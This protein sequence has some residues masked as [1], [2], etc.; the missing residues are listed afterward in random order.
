[1]SLNISINHKEVESVLRKFYNA[2]GIAVE[3]YDLGLESVIEYP[4]ITN[5][6]DK[7]F[8][9]IIRDLSSTT[10]YKCLNCINRAIDKVCETKDSYIYSCHFGFMAIV[11]PI[12]IH[13]EVVAVVRSGPIRVV[14]TDKYDFDRIMS[15]MSDFD[16]LDLSNEEILLLRTSFNKIKFAK[17]EKTESISYLLNLCVREICVNN[18]IICDSRDLMKDF[19]YYIKENVREKLNISEV[20]ISLKISRSYLSYMLKKNK[21]MTFTEYVLKEKVEEAKKLLVTT[22]MPFKAISELLNF[23]SYVYFSRVFKGV[24]GYS[25]LEFR[26][27]FVIKKI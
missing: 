2:T 20:A 7:G 13:G 24:T 17:N 26:K 21:H 1:M 12:V 9:D 16:V 15:L 19:E 27:R 10:R 14:P 8:C 22:S 23:N 4:Q 3:I 25:C 18:W 5:F 6:D 11:V